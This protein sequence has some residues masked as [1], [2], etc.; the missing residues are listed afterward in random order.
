MS[1]LIESQIQS[2]DRELRK[3]H[4]AVLEFDDTSDGWRLRVITGRQTFDVNGRTFL[5]ALAQAAN[6]LA[7]GGAAESYPPPALPL[8]F[9]EDGPR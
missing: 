2:I 6:V 4:G 1:A 9:G 8:P 7:M 5:D 3:V